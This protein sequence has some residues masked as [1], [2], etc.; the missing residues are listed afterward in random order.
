MDPNASEAAPGLPPG[1]R[2]PSIPPV[3]PVPPANAPHI[4]SADALYN[5]L[6]V[7]TMHALYATLLD[8]GVRHEETVYGYFGSVLSSL[9]PPAVG[10]QVRKVGHQ[11]ALRSPADGRLI[12]THY[13]RGSDGQDHND[14]YPGHGKDPNVRY[15]D[16]TLARVIPSTNVRCLRN[17]AVLEIKIPY[18]GDGRLDIER[19]TQRIQD[20]FVQAGRYFKK[21]NQQPNALHEDGRY[22]PVFVTYGRYYTELE[23]FSRNGQWSARRFKPWQHI[24]EE[25]AG[26]R[27][28]L[29]HVLAGLIARYWHTYQ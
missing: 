22:V 15:P 23:V 5:A 21:V 8:P 18:T 4:T 20:L 25:Q 13:S 2:Y 10:F 17:F 16:I 24:F 28:P 3:V 27:R 29:F 11:H 9:A 12:P 6:S 7:G 26:G 1:F 19:G 14:R